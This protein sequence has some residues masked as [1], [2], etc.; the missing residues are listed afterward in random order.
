MPLEFEL[1]LILV[2]GLVFFYLLFYI[3]ADL[4]YKRKKELEA[5]LKASAV[6][7]EGVWPP[8]PTTFAEPLK[9]EPWAWCMQCHRASSMDTISDNGGCCGYEECSASLSK[10]VAWCD[11]KARIG[12]LPEQPEI[13]LIYADLLQAKKDS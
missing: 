5:L 4:P 6:S 2:P 12:H 1:P 13:G 7:H 8:A 10:L 9:P 11:L 3:F